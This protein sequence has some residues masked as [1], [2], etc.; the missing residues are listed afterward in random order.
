M[1][2]G[3]NK[4]NEFLVVCRTMN[5]KLDIVPVLFGSLGL[6]V[7]SK[8]DFD[9]D[10]IDVLVPGVY[11]DKSWEELK[12]EI[13]NLNFEFV[14]LHEHEF[15]KKDIKLAFG[16]EE[17]LFDFVGVNCY[18]LNII[19]DE[20]AKYKLLNLEEYLRVYKASYKDSYRRDKNN[21]KDMDKII[22]IENLLKVAL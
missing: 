19:E 16:I 20:R 22:Y 6:E 4:Y 13:E 21:R 2:L 12:T 8:H 11:H 14:D 10:D 15:K 17:S 5:T 3:K 1:L 7:L 18:K 9:A